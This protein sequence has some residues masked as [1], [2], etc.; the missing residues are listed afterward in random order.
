MPGAENETRRREKEISRRAFVGGAVSTAALTIVPRHVLGG[1]GYVAPSEKITAACIGVGAQGTRVMMDFLK[2]PDMQIV[3]VCD[4]NRES[5]DY[6]EWSPNE[7]RDKERALLG[8]AEWGQDWKGPTAGRE[9]ARRLVEAYYAT[10]T[11]SGEYK[12]C[13][14]YVDYR[15]LLEKGKDFDAVIVGTPDHSHAVISIAAMK[16]GKHVFC[17]K[18]LTHSIYEARRIAEVA[19]ETKVA[20]QVA[21]GNQASEATRLLCEWIWAGAIGPVREVHNWSSRPFWPQGIE[22]P[23]KE[24]PVP[25]GFD[26]DLWLGPAP[27]RPYHRVYLPFVWRGWYDFGNGAIGDMGC[28]SFDTIFRVLKLGAPESV[29]ASS[30]RTFPETFPTASI[31]HFR[32]PARGDMPPVKLTWYDGGLKPP[33]PLELEDGREMSRGNEGLLFIGDKGTILCGFNGAN[34]K[35]IPES[36]MQEFKQ[37]DKTLPRSPG[38]DREWIEACKGGQPGGANFEFEGPVTETVLL[39]N[40]ALR[41]G[42]KLSWDAP[43][44]KAGN[45]PE[46]QPYVRGEYRQGWTL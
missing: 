21:V 38:N 27:F 4:V 5:G 42:K 37:P 13:A 22:R 17:Q 7:L 15:E 36:K 10:K 39:G 23:A 35:L 14:A 32:F 18:P 31:I 3:A 46:T 40:V 29:E 20:T 1:R 33:R 43:N 2:Q 11:T 19:R 41:A 6:V 9:P 25:E 8:N 45:A 34:P 12:G 24:E 16:K 44:M 30:T 26:W 28:Y